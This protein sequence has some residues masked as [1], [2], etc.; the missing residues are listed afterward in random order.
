M[1]NI[2]RGFNITAVIII[3]IYYI[4]SCCSFFWSFDSIPSF[5][6]LRLGTLRWDLRVQLLPAAGPEFPRA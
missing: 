5:E 3:Y 6:A 1:F 4:L 2:T